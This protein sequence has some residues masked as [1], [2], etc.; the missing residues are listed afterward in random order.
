MNWHYSIRIAD[1]GQICRLACVTE[2]TATYQ[3]KVKLLFRG[4]S[5]KCRQNM[6]SKYLAAIWGRGAGRPRHYGLKL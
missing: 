4:F 1:E 6:F 5:K 3:K 2:N